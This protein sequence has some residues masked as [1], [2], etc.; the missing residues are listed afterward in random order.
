M[1]A[2]ER[3]EDGLAASGIFRG[4]FF[5]RVVVDCAKSLCSN[6]FKGYCRF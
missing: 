2:M 3:V 1:E 6:G 4:M 5:L